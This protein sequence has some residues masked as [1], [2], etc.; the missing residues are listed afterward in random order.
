[1]GQI[2]YINNWPGWSKFLKNMPR[3]G[4]WRHTMEYFVLILERKVD[5]T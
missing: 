4:F 1:M 2:F 5:T 3:P